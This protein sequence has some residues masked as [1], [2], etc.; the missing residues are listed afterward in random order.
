MPKEIVHWLIASRVCEELKGSAIGDLVSANPFCL[1][2]GAVFLDALY[3]NRNGK[4][5]KRFLSLSDAFHGAGGED[6]YRII[7]DLHSATVGLDRKGPLIALMTGI[8]AHIQADAA[9]HPLVYYVSGDYNGSHPRSKE[10][11]VASHRRFE[12]LMDLFFCSGP[13]R[14]RAYPLNWYLTQAEMPPF[15]LFSRALSRIASERAWP[16]LSQAMDRAFRF[17]GFMQALSHNQALSRLLYATDWLFPHVAKQ[18]IALFYG[19]QLNRNIAIMSQPMT[20]RNPVTGE[21]LTK[22]VEELFQLAVGNAV[23]LIRGIE[24]AILSGESDLKLGVG[25]SLSFGLPGVTK[26]DAKYFADE[27]AM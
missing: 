15:D 14:L 11:A 26:E 8:I 4:E 12:S 2:L 7:R 16:D 10:K 3:Y 18:I 23:T 19:P 25:P 22:R 17:F 20:F 9:C 13:T 5:T 6:T 27:P 21:G 24:D 1:K